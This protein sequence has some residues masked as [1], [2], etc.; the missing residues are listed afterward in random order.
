MRWVCPTHLQ[1]PLQVSIKLATWWTRVWLSLGALS[2]ALLWK[3]FVTLN[4][5]S[6]FLFISTPIHLQQGVATLA[7]C[8]M[9]GFA[10]RTTRTTLNWA[11]KRKVAHKKYHLPCYCFCLSSFRF[12][13]SFLFFFFLLFFSCPIGHG[14]RQAHSVGFALSYIKVTDDCHNNLSG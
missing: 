1:R 2:V 12:F 6:S 3:K 14:Q 7:R 9:N 10:T 4:W 8:L 13:F 11:I 5:N